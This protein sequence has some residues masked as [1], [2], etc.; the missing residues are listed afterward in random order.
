MIRALEMFDQGYIIPTSG[1]EEYDGGTIGWVNYYS[2]YGTLETFDL[3][4]ASTHSGTVC[5]REFR[6]ANNDQGHWMVSWNGWALQSFPS[7][8]SLEPGLNWDYTVEQSHGGG[9]YEYMV[10]PWNWLPI[11]ESQYYGVGE[12]EV[13]IEPPVEEVK[14]TVLTVD[15]LVQA[16]TSS[17]WD[18]PNI[19]PSDAKK[20][21]PDLVN[22]CVRHDITTRSR[23]SAFLGETGA[24]SGSFKW[25]RELGQGEGKDY[26]IWFGRGPIQLTW[27]EN[28]Q[29]FELDTGHGAHG[30]PDLVA[31]DS[32]VGFESAAW[33]W[34][35]NGLNELADQATWQSYYEI[36]GRIWGQAG[37][38]AERDARYTKAWNVLPV[39]L[40]LKGEVNVG[41][42]TKA[43]WET[44]GWYEPV[45]RGSKD[46]VFHPP[47][48]S[49]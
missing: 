21:L 23:L 6:D 37:P 13:V 39:N 11:T 27:E 2:G 24:E 36:T 43:V 22:A 28:Y 15:M 19:D 7:G 46:L 25:W 12:G 16:M 49:S 42:E 48:T 33:F 32:E 44:D 30:D 40:N 31:D 17:A 10:K 38:V 47:G 20:Y 29:Q 41:T 8:G 18:G 1:N 26:G 5:L 14:I 35:K 45:S 3:E 34:Q 4:F 9:Y